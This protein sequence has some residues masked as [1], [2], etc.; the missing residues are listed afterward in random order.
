MAVDDAGDDVQRL[1]RQ[2]VYTLADTR[3]D[4][5]HRPFQVSEL[6]QDIIPY[7]VF[8]AR[9]Q[10]DTNEDYEMAVLRLLAGYRDLVA[11]EPPEAGAA[12]AQEAEAINPLP[13]AFREFAAARVVLN[14]IAVRELLDARD[15][16]AP[17][18]AAPQPQPLTRPS[19]PSREPDSSGPGAGAVPLPYSFDTAEGTGC[20]NCRRPLPQHRTVIYCPFCGEQVAPA[21][22][23]VCGTELEP[24]WVFCIT[25]GHR[26]RTPN[27]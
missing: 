12:L 20:R 18:P 24:G 1:F 23:S 2:L 14:P 17:A 13:G 10:F 9:L 5:L 16:Y 11:L 7:R 26:S 27:P 8:R 19:E 21:R 25:C 15:A 4:Y 22:C 6:Y 3:P